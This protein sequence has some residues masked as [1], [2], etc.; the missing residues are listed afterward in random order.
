[1]TPG[2]HRISMADYLADCCPVP[3][4][5]SGVAFTLLNESPLHAAH[6][7]P[8][9][10]GRPRDFS[11]AS[12]T[13]TT[14]HDMLLGGEGRICEIDP[15][16]HPAEKTGNIP[17]GWTNKSIRAARDLARS[18]G[19]TPILSGELVGIRAMV[20][21]A[22]D[23]I[24]SSQIAGIFDGGESELTVIAQDGD[25]W[26][27]TRP[28][29][30]NDEIS[31]SYKTSKADIGP[32]AFA[33]LMNSMG[34]GFSLAFYERVLLA[35][36]PGKKR[37]RHLML[38]QQQ[39]APYACALYNLAPAK[40]AIE[41]AQVDRAIRLWAHCIQTGSW[42]GYSRRVCSIDATPWELAEEEARLVAEEEALMA[43]AVAQ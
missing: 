3:S 4:L 12:D 36:E 41:R 13:G 42:P 22:K 29:W 7:H 8:R 18:N 43:E 26:L 28:D 1:M 32:R 16:D 25:T 11:N 34:Y 6:R 10:F 33:R 39:D 31:L 37:R 27:R 20:R 24:A 38:I 21:A 30:L 2:I 15:N 5:S 9:I 19:L 23:Y 40:A 35:A 17:D 14:A